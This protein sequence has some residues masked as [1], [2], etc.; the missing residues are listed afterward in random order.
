MCLRGTDVT[1]DCIK[2]KNK[3]FERILFTACSTKTLTSVS[4]VVVIKLP[5]GCQDCISQ[6]AVQGDHWK[7]GHRS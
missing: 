6:T 3:N 2:S 7:S 1:S 4:R 5:L